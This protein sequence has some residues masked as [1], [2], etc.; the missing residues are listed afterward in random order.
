MHT[1]LQNM[2]TYFSPILFV[3]IALGLDLGLGL[4]GPGS[5]EDMRGPGDGFPPGPLSGLIGGRIG[6]G[7]EVPPGAILFLLPGIL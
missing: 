5:G 7:P 2:N 4:D 3:D 1:K 6:L